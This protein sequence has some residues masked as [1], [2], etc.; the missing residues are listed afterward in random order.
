MGSLLIIV[1]YILAYGSS[2]YTF[3]LLARVILDWVRLF[4]RGWM[5]PPF[6]LT[7]FDWIYRLTD[8]PVR[9]MRRYIP[10]LRLGN[11]ALDVGFMIVFIATIMVGRLGTWLVYM[12]YLMG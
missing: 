7:I 6:L 4:A 3:I 9:F 1:G 8:P 10:P 11:I 2:L 5:P 12:G